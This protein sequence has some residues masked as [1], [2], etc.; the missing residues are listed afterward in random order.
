MI[1]GNTERER[2]ERMFVCLVSLCVCEP[3]L[4]AHSLHSSVDSVG[5][6]L[7]VIYMSTCMILHVSR[8]TQPALLQAT[9]DAGYQKDCAEV[10]TLVKQAQ[11]SVHMK[12]ME[13]LAFSQSPQTKCR[14]SHSASEILSTVLREWLA[15]SKPKQAGDAQ[16]G[17]VLP[18]P[19]PFYTEEDL[20]KIETPRP[21]DTGICQKG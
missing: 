2:R 19:V 21:Q 13:K 16:A 1:E 17:T 18:V 10:D 9:A 12:S 15:Q 7:F 6:G 20:K 8:V 14:Q 4:H 5:K 3:G 11:E